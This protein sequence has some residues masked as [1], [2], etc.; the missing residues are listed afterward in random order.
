MKVM[1]SSTA[2]V[3]LVFAFEGEMTPFLRDYMTQNITGIQWVAINAWVT[4][5]V[6]SGREYYP[7]LG[8]TIG[9]SIRKGHI[10]RLGDFLQTVNPKRYPDNVLVHEL[11]ESL[12][13]CSPFPSSVT[14]MP[15]CSGQESLLEQ[16]SAYMNTSS[17]R[18]SYNVYK[19]VYAIAHSLHN[20]LL[21]QPGRGPFQNSYGTGR[22]PVLSVQLVTM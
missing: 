16:H 17:P 10:S 14:Q 4:A 20:L 11:W 18:F 6:F 7:Y 1:R 21:C 2:K 12:Y 13:G 8:G 19:A 15:P 9:F 3:V 5:S 22:N